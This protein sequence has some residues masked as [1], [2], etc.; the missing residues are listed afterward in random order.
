MGK[1]NIPLYHQTAW[2]PRP[3]QS[4]S[5]KRRSEEKKPDPKKYIITVRN[6]LSPHG[7]PSLLRGCSVFDLLICFHKANAGPSNLA[8]R[9]ETTHS[10]IGPPVSHN[11]VA[12]PAFALIVRTARV[13]HVHGVDST[14]PLRVQDGRVKVNHTAQCLPDGRRLQ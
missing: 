14:K 10:P 8:C 5:K 9:R 11:R 1:R 13:R 2:A 3:Q 6:T 12:L 4:H 7:V